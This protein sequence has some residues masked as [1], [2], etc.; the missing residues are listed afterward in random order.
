MPVRVKSNQCVARGV[1]NGASGHVHHIDWPPTTSFTRQ[2]NGAWLASTQ[3]ANLYANITNSPSTTPF[4]LLPAEWPASVMPI[5][6]I[7]ASVPI[8]GGSLS[9][10]G[11][12]IVPAFGTTVHGMQ[13]ETRNAIA[14]TDLRPPHIRH[15]DP[16]ALYVALSRIRTRHGL[17]WL[18][19]RPTREDYDYFRPTPEVVLEDTRLSRLSITTISRFECFMQTTQH[20]FATQ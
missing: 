4:P 2:D 9:I 1:V 7:S 8:Q 18:G 17:H 19:K 3:P 11:F 15:A 16:H 14:V 5:H 12:P 10:K 6:Q 20:V 13:G